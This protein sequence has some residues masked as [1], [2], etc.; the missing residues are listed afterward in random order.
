MSLVVSLCS[1]CLTP[2]TVMGQDLSENVT[3][4]SGSGSL[5]TALTHTRTDQGTSTDTNTEPSLGVS[6][7][8]GGKLESGANSLALRY[9]GTLETKRDLGEG[10]QTDTSSIT[11]ASR[12][13]HFDPASRLDFN[14]GHTVSL[15]RNN[16]GFVV[17]PSSY[18]TQNTL[19]A[20]AGLRF[21]PGDLSTLRFSGE[22]GRSFGAG[23]LNDKESITASG[24]FSRRLSERSTG[25]IV[26]SRSWSNDNETDITI[27]SAQLVYNRVLENG[28]FNIGGGL[29][30]ADTEYPDG[31]VSESE[32]GTGFV[33][34]TW[35]ASDWRTSIQYNRRLSDSATDLSLDFPEVFD[36]L[37]DTIRIRDLVTSDSVLVTHN[38]TSR[39]C[40]VC[41]F[42]LAAE[43]ALLESEITGA[44]TH[45]YSASV[46]FGFQLTNLQRMDF[47]Y[48]WQGDAGEDA[49]TI[50][51]QIHRFNTSWSR[52]LAEDTSFSVQLNQSYLRSRLARSDQD[53]F[54]LRLVLTKG[55]SL[56]GQSR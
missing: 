25:S 38:S 22:A 54:V 20:G 33:D 11:G 35:V 7:N 48:S 31:S 51:D 5:F 2:N 13:V 56:V 28:S 53:Q 19:N 42:G 3:E 40:S 43:A 50:I 16:T 52:Q 32:A 36:F 39:L 17:N 14:A 23:E 12:F 8:L 27:D 24:E 6:G 18:D 55:F 34:R 37:P 47:L 45:E 10:D 41:N 26:G 49:G 21:F 1:F 46:N 29:S 44:T 15:V 9:G 30:Q 4:V